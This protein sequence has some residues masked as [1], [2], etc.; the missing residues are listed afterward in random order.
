MMADREPYTY[1]EPE[2][3]PRTRL[4]LFLVMVF[5]AAGG[6]VWALAFLAVYRWLTGH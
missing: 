3:W 4:G 1:S 5:A 2:P 6:L